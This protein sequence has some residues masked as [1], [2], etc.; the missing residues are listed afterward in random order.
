MSAMRF[1]N[2]RVGA[3]LISAAAYLTVAADRRGQWGWVGVY[4]LVFFS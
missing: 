4:D 2:V 3:E 1:Q